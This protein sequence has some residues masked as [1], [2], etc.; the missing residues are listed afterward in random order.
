VICQLKVTGVPAA[1][2]AGEAL[3]LSVN[4]T[5]TVRLWGVAVP[6]GPVAEIENVVVL[7]TGVIADPE[8]GSGPE[9]SV[10]G[11]AG[12]I[13]TAVALVVAQVIVV[14]CPA[15][16]DVGAALNCV[17]CGCTGCATCTIAVCG[18][19]FPP[20]PDAI[21]VYVV[22]SVGES[23]TLP[24][25]EEL[26]VTGRVVDPAT[27]VMVTED[28]FDVCQLNITLCPVVI[29]PTLAEKT[30][31]GPPPPPPGLPMPAHEQRP[32]RASNT[33]PILIRRL[34]FNSI[35]VLRLVFT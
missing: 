26:V 24:L 35:V 20:D 15:L 18:V 3:K 33:I 2:V 14:V 13:V 19:L 28:A 1:I 12:V 17:I 32:R 21:A 7:V 11:T 29:V 16:N 23:D 8:V 27:A 25:T 30:R 31:L 22:V 6:P 9:P 4:G 5:V 34:F 10:C